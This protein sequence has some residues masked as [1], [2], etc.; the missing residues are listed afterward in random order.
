M[1]DTDWT[2]TST[3]A[4]LEELAR[5]GVDVPKGLPEE[6]V[7]RGDESAQLLAAI[8]ADDAVWAEESEPRSWLPIHAIHLLGAI[9][10][11]RAGAAIIEVLVKRD[12][13]DWLTESM[14]MLLANAGPATVPGLTA[15]LLDPAQDTWVRSTAG[16][17]LYTL[18]SRN[19]ELRPEVTSLL[20]RIVADDPDTLLASLLVGE[21]AHIDDPAAAAAID[22]AFA[23]DRMD[24]T[25]V[26]PRHIDEIRREEAPWQIEWSASQPP[27]DHFHHKLGQL[28]SYEQG[29]REH[30]RKLAQRLRNIAVPPPPGT[31]VRETPK[32][33][34]N[35]PCPCGSGKKYKK[36]CL[37]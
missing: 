6:I 36:C 14:P 37:K 10:S 29:G 20:A 17:A 27:L 13:G 28:K 16:Q 26:L 15:V 3:A 31:Y 5:A 22:R 35:D 30:E 4:L 25:C 24:P 19:P 1:A 21:V 34:R 8:V 18:A 7:R 33:G 23:E 12:L 2:A 9:G 32:V 11:D